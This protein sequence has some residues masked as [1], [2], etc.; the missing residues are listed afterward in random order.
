MSNRISPNSIYEDSD[1]YLHAD[2]FNAGDVIIYP[3][4][5]NGETSFSITTTNLTVGHAFASDSSSFPDGM[6]E[7]RLKARGW[8]DDGASINSG[9]AFEIVQ[10]FDVSDGYLGSAPQVII[11]ARGI[12]GDDIWESSIDTF[13]DGNIMRVDITGV[14]GW[15]INWT[16]EVTIKVALRAGTGQD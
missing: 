1:G 13:P 5:A 8:A 6:Y 9:I 12:A 15:I 11:F 10:L 2:M 7:M 3:P 16:G 14:S 4:P